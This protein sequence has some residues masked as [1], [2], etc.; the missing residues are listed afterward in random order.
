MR[1]AHVYVHARHMWLHFLHMMAPQM[2]QPMLID[3]LRLVGGRRV[4]V[5]LHEKGTSRSVWKIAPRFLVEQEDM[6]EQEPFNAFN[7]V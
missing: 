4:T 7:E 1:A 2:T 6:G 5:M 3:L